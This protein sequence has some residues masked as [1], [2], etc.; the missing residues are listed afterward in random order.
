MSSA[1][2]YV[3]DAAQKINVAFGE[4]LATLRKQRGYSQAALA[5]RAGYSRATL[6]N[7][8]IGKQNIQLHQIFAFSKALNTE[9]G[10]LLPDFGSVYS[11]DASHAETFIQLAKIRL[12]TLLKMAAG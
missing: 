11:S 10:E 3:E 5:E 2:H 7:I 1:R 8:E 12:D 4:R 9:P 6:A